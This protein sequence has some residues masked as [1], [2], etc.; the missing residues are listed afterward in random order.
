LPSRPALQTEQ[1][2]LPRDAFF[3]PTESV[4]PKTAAGRISAELTTP[5]PPDIP[6]IAPGER[7]TEEIVEEIVANGA[8]V[9]G[10]SD[11]SLHDFRV[12]A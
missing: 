6:A 2:M 8:F 7:L 10:A 3:A 12:V 4:K 9:E 1:A 5:Y 11:P